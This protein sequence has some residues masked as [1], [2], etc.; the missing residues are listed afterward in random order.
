M[1]L[2]IFGLGILLQNAPT[3]GQQ[4]YTFCHQR[5]ISTAYKEKQP[6]TSQPASFKFYLSII[7]MLG[8]IKC[9]SGGSG[10][11]QLCK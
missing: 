2:L 4:L 9:V 3:T 1:Y 10:T 6:G 7:Q 11:L 8:T 5:S